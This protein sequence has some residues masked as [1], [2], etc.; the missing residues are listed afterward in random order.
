MRQHLNTL[1]VTTEGAWL[2]KDGEN[3]VVKV[4][5]IELGRVPVHLLGSIVCV[6]SIGLTPALMGHCAERG[7]RISMMGR[8]GRFLA[9]IEGPVSGNVLLRRSQYRA[10][11]DAEK[12][13]ALAGYI[14]TGKLLN[15]R[16]VVRRALRDHGAHSPPD[17][18]ARLR[19]CERR[20]SDAARRSANPQAINVLRGIEGEAARA[21]FGVFNDLVRTEERTFAF[22]HRS[23]RP[24]LDPVNALLSFLYTLLVHDYRSALESVGLDP[25]V[26]F[27][28]RERPGRPSLAL[29][30][31]E[32]LRPVLADRLALSLIN[33]RQLV[34]SDFET[35]VTGSVTMREDG[36]KKVL[37]A[38]Q[39]RKKDELVHPFLQEKTTIGLVPF[40]QA[41]L[42]A[43]HLRGD[44]DGYPPF[45]WR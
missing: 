40:V 16:T 14:V 11:D 22:T 18:C 20:M 4:D 8:N 10:T 43:R 32:E 28:H 38:Y 24:P 41:N 19:T 6:G 25:A 2:H 44:L 35:A 13:A 5:G 23:R 30:L 36:R 29:D 1:Y 33:R 15:Q 21:Y 17:V 7:V 9:R 34:A 42:M 27:L 31:M 12:T 3:A 39:D 37:V 45:L 26:G